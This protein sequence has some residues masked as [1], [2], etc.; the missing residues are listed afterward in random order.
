MYFADSAQ[1]EAHL[2]DDWTVLLRNLKAR[3]ELLHELLLYNHRVIRQ[4][5]HE[6]E[7]FTNDQI[8]HHHARIA[9]AT[10]ANSALDAQEQPLLAK[11]EATTVGWDGVAKLMQRVGARVLETFQLSL[12]QCKALDEEL[13]EKHARMKQSLVG[14]LKQR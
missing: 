8:L 13:V 5:F 10:Q 14:L 12:E 6:D 7:L 1:L 11:Y 2:N 3:E 9:T 4:R